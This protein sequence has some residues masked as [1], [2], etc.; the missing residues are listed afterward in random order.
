MYLQN[1]VLHQFTQEIVVLSGATFIIIWHPVLTS[2][3]EN[4]QIIK[5]K[6]VVWKWTT[7][8]SGLYSAALVVQNRREFV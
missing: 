8:L 2:Y 3:L 5:K 1:K 7:K 4:K 6:Q